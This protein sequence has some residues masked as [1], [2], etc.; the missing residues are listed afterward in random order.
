MSPEQFLGWI[1]ATYGVTLNPEQITALAGAI[2][3]NGNNWSPQMANQAMAL[4]DE[5]ARVNNIPRRTSGGTPGS[6]SGVDG[7]Q[8]LSQL[9][10]YVKQAYG[11]EL[12]N[13]EV[14]QLLGA[15]NYNG[16]PITQS[17]MDQAVALVREAAN[18][19]G[20]QGN[21]SVA[22]P[23]VTP[24]GTPGGTGGNSG[25]GVSAFNINEA[26]QAVIDAVKAQYAGYNLNDDQLQF[27]WENISKNGVANTQQMVSAAMAWLG[28]EAN[29]NAV[30]AKAGNA[31][32]GG[33]TGGTVETVGSDTGGGTGGGTGSGS[34]SNAIDLTK[35]EEFKKWFRATFGREATS[36]E[37][38]NYASGVRYAGGTLTPKTLAELKD[39]AILDQKAKGWLP[40][41]PDQFTWT[42]FSYESFQYGEQAP[43]FEGMDPFQFAE[44]A[45]TYQAGPAF[46]Y[47]EFRAPSLDEI[48]RD[49]AYQRRLEEGQRALETSAAAKG[50]LRTGATL[51][52]LSQYSQNLAS[53]EYGNAYE[54]QSR[55][56]EKNRDLAFQTYQTGEQQ[57]KDQFEAARGSYLDRLRQAE[58]GYQTEAQRRSSQYGASVE[59][60]RNRYNQAREGYETNRNNAL[61]AWQAKRQEEG[62]RWQRDYDVWR[63]LSDD[64]YRKAQIAAMSA[65]SA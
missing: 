33:G 59:S 11:R 60:W 24:G 31:G 40:V 20:I 35:A 26:R 7:N 52:G 21:A 58:L 55:E 27:I 23:S 12:N 36:D 49:P 28:S 16:G 54:R 65:G 2:G 22:A 45:P 62:M 8:A 39:L 56:Y 34:A 53:E 38:A 13:E 4:V 3:F 17:L 63:Y 29:R 1:E 48:T 57:R 6:A 43:T 9:Q 42:P 5:Q 64:P 30:L 47:Q 44:Q 10:Q 25:S 18:N 51:K 32:S 19:A 14:Q 15:L 61:T 41:T 46:Q 37:L 50:L